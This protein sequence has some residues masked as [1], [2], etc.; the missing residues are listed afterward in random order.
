MPV[1]QLAAKGKAANIK[2]TERAAARQAPVAPV[3]LVRANLSRQLSEVLRVTQLT[4]GHQFRVPHAMQVT[5][6]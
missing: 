5:R 6:S 2:D 4:M 1:C 3:Q